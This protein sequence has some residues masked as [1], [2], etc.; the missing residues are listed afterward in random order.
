ME[1]IYNIIE[2]ILPF[3][4]MEYDFMKNALLAIFIIS[5]LFGLVGSMIV[6]NKMS[7]FS[8]AL[9]HSALTGIAIGA[10]LGISNYSLSMVI[11]AVIFAILLNYI[12]NKKTASTDTIIS[13]FSSVSIALGLVLL[14]KYGGINKYS[15]YLVGDILSVTASEILM[16][17][18][19][20]IITVLIW[21]KLS[22]KLI[23]IS[24]DVSLARAK[25]IKVQVI[26]NIFGVLIAVLVMLTIKW[27][28]ILLINALLILPAAAARNISGNMRE[29]TIY[30][31]LFSLVAGFTGLILSYIFAVATGPTIVVISGIMYAVTFVFRKK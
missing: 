8:D 12:N 30:S 19:M 24:T 25:G 7:F 23:T 9:G 22:N 16:L 13:V 31:I 27:V 14:S 18:I 15:Q 2:F 21:C 20:L 3:S 17:L 1:L 4:F 6:N 10:I 11:F 5:P 26:E 28:G 29:Y